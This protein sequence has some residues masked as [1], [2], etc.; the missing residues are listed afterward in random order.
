MIGRTLWTEFFSN[1]SWSI[2]SAI[3]VLLLLVLIAPMVLYQ[4][5]QARS[6]EAKE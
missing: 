1:R 5:I 4:N 3:A 6:L 2:A